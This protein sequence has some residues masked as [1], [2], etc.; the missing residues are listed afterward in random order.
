MSED[1]SGEWD[2][3]THVHRETHA[4]DIAKTWLIAAKS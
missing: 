1:E 4:L 2:L 3:S